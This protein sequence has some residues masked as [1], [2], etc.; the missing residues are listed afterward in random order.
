MGLDLEAIKRKIDELN[1]VKKAVTMAN[2][3]KPE[4]GEH[5]VRVLPWND[6]TNE[7]IKERHFYYLENAPSILAPFQFGKQDPINEFIKSLYRSG[8]AD[9]K[10]MAKK[11]M[12]KMR[13]YVPI[14]VRGEESKGVMLWA[15]GK[16][17]YQRILGF[18]VDAEVGDISDV[19]GG[20]DLVVKVSKLPGKQ[21]NDT[22]VDAA[23]RPSKLSADKNQVQSWLSA[24]PNIDEV[25]KL[26]SSEEIKGILETWLNAGTVEEEP[27]QS[28]NV[29]VGTV[30]SSQVTNKTPTGGQQFVDLDAAFADLLE[31][32]VK[33]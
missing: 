26:K 30:K 19:D 22:T 13:S 33:F 6:G 5:R 32:E 20:F 1:G 11:L 10:N 9:D 18:F 21:F 14:I 12:P 23:R 8:S 4:I 27:S 2:M 3:W 15:F 7:P 17:V 24:V 29:N 31:D 16:Q 28:Q 25:Y